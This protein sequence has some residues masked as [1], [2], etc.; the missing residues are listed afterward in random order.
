MDFAKVFGSFADRSPT[1]KEP[2]SRDNHIKLAYLSALIE[3]CGGDRAK[4]KELIK[5]HLNQGR[6]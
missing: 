3:A 5:K 6:D 2:I 4:A 1:R